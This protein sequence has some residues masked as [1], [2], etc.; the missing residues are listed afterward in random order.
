MNLKLALN[1]SSL[2]VGYDQGYGS[3]R[4]PEDDFPPIMPIPQ[5]S[6]HK[7]TA[8]KLKS[9]TDK[10]SESDFSFITKGEGSKIQ[11]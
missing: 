3:E 1:R 4:S 8:Q 5:N 10:V 7:P 6:L 2:D 11:L 9:G